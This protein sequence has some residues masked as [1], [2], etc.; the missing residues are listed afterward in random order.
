MQAG[1]YLR[2]SGESTVFFWS[3]NKLI[4][5][6]APLRIDRTGCQPVLSILKK[7]GRTGWQPVLPSLIVTA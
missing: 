6:L 2:F 1:L 4:F 7:I 3:I 5:A